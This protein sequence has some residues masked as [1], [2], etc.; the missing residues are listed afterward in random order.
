MDLADLNR[1][2]DGG[3]AQEALAEALALLPPQSGQGRLRLLLLIA[4]CHGVI[5][6]PV[7]AFRASLQARALAFELG[8]AGGEVEALLDAGAA[9][10]R[11]DEHAAAIAYFDQAERLL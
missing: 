11:V 5:G 4:R 6:Q 1:K 9:H 8:N 3:N 2:L 10:Q 7:E